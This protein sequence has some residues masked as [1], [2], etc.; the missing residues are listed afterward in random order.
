MEQ[1]GPRKYL[2][3]PNFA[4]A[5]AI[6][7]ST[8]AAWAWFGRPS[9]NDVDAPSRS[10]PV[11]DASSEQSADAKPAA[12]ETI[13]TLEDGM[14]DSPT[15]GEPIDLK[16]L[17]PGVEGIVAVR[18]ADI[19]RHPEGPKL[20]DPL[21]TGA[22]ADWAR[23]YLPQLSGTTLGN[24]EQVIVGSSADMT[25]LSV[26]VR[27]SVS[28]TPD[29]LRRSWGEPVEAIESPNGDRYLDKGGWSGWLP[30]EGRGQ[31][32]VI[33]LTK[34]MPEVM[35]RAS[36]E[37][38]ANVAKLLAHSDRERLFT[39]VGS[40]RFF[41]HASGLFVWPPSNIEKPL[42]WFFTGTETDSFGPDAES[43][44]A[45][46]KALNNAPAIMA[47]GHL[48]GDQSFFELRI[49]QPDAGP[50]GLELA[51][52]FRERL[53]QFD[54]RANRW[55]FDRDISPAAR[56][57]LLVYPDMLR[58]LRKHTRVGVADG[59]IVLRSYLPAKAAHNLL[60]GAGLCLHQP[61]RGTQ[62]DR[63]T[64]MAKLDRKT[65]LAFD[66]N[67]LE[68]AMK[69]L[70]EDLGFP[71]TIR[72][73]DLQL[74]GITKNQSFGIH[75]V[76]KPARE[77]FQKILRLANPEGKLVYIIKSALNGRDE[78]MFITTRAAVKKKR[79]EL[80]PEFAGIFA[81]LDQKTT[82][83]FD[84]EG[85]N[86]SLKR[87]ADT[88]GIPITIRR[89]DLQLEGI[90]SGISIPMQEVDRPARE[91]LLKILSR[92]NP[93]GK[94]VYVIKRKADGG[95]EIVITTRAAV[96]KNGEKLPLEYDTK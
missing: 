8:L 57:I 50:D 9:G 32:L 59:Q 82:L 2:A 37:L 70:S 12:R 33:T 48:A 5:V 40:P 3:S 93:D 44:S 85:F 46:S 69:L 76:D 53:D 55:L 51:Q 87:L 74:E 42:V 61:L 27:A 23:R 52:L 62:P 65:T 86:N 21:V 80:P 64:I 84:R 88:S 81:L 38:P 79:E 45:V 15:F 72:G 73:A 10:S 63:S 39:F 13:W 43:L 92:A 77:V 67:T 71:I 4:W 36:S 34:R 49:S 35:A 94:I 66:R 6:L 75:E 17:T 29:D 28:I 19:L 60:L 96:V 89:E 56:D 24:I 25:R 95:E 1:L 78:E 14:Y 30:P 20:L 7:S 58:E 83:V 18:P 16:Y 47:S 26:I 22:T 68:I 11:V 54:R 91:I 90:T 31:I 41:L